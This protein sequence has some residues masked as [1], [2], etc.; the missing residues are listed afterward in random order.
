MVHMVVKER[1]DHHRH[2]DRNAA[3]QEFGVNAV[4]RDTV[5]RLGHI[6]EEYN[7]LLFLRLTPLSQNMKR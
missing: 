2:L 7:H 3:L 1:A 5:E 6:E 4:V